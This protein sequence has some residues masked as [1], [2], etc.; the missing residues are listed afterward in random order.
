L[1]NFSAAPDYAIAI[2][3]NFYYFTHAKSQA[4]GIRDSLGYL[5]NLDFLLR[6]IVKK[7]KFFILALLICV[8]SIESKKISA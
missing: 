8:F 4:F 3:Y 5:Q 7:F 1:H 6:A 2:N